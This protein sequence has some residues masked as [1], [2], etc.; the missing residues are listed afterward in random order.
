MSELIVGIDAAAR[1]ERTGVALATKDAEAVVV[2]RVYR[3][4]RSEWS[5]F[6]DTLVER[7]VA[8]STARRVL[9]AIDAPLG[10][11]VPLSCRLRHHTAGAP[12]DADG[13]AAAHAVADTMFSR[14]TDRYIRR[15]TRLK[16]LDV[17]CNL[18]ARVG[19]ASVQ[20]IHRLA[21]RLQSPVPLVW[22][23]AELKLYGVI[24]VYPAATLQQNGQEFPGYKKGA[25]THMRRELLDW[26]RTRLKIDSAA[27][28]GC[29]EKS[30]HCLDALSCVIAATEF[31]DD[32]LQQVPQ[33][34]HD[35]ARK[36]GW[37]WAVRDD[38]SEVA[39]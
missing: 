22:S 19:V 10:W 18:I 28:D 27:S 29:I 21:L 39:H 26:I 4:K 38:Q 13:N 23:A 31:L 7:I 15:Q 2:R 24:E 11:P 33:E 1:P 34:H 35:V 16:P 36:E 30:D 9:F 17:G 32:Q 5:K 14:E 3:G 12:L 20:L 8:L 25:N 6:A 37:I